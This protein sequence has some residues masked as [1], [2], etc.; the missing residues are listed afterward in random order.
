MSGSVMV[1]SHTIYHIPGR[2]VGCT[3]SLERRKQQYLA[4]EGRIP[5]IEI[6]EELSDKTDQEAGDI[7]WQWADAR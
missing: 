6:L 4:E 3:Q 1:V 5:Q 2:K 7:E